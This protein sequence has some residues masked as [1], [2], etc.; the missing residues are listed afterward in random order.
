M[1]DVCCFGVPREFLKTKCTKKIK[2]ADDSSLVFL[3]SSPACKAQ[4]SFHS[5]S[6]HLSIPASA[7]PQQVSVS[8]GTFQSFEPLSQP[9]LSRGQAAP[10]I[11]CLYELLTGHAPY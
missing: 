3:E 10:Y 5:L 7:H 8:K 4:S 2:G 11:S 9:T 6:L 1:E